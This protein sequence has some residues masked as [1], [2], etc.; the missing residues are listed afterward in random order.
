MIVSYVEAGSG[1]QSLSTHAFYQ[2]HELVGYTNLSG[3]YGQ[4]VDLFSD[5]LF[6][7]G[8]SFVG[9]FIVLGNDFIINRL[10]GSPVQCTDFVGTLKHHVFQIVC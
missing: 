3:F 5:C 2:V 1:V 4:L 9:H 6:L 8:I 10:F 7:N